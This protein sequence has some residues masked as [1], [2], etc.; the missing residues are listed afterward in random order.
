MDIQYGSYNLLSAPAFRSTVAY[1]WYALVC[2]RST[3][4]YTIPM[5]I[6]YIIGMVYVTL[7]LHDPYKMDHIV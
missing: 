5:L 6:N 1:F 4:L 7:E 2:L 3:T